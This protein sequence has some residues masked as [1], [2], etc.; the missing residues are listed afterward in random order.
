MEEPAMLCFTI[1]FPLVCSYFAHC[2]HPMCPE[3]YPH[4]KSCSLGLC[5]SFLEEIA[6]QAANCIMDACAEQRK[7][8]EQLLPKHC[9]STISKAQN[10]KAQKQPPKKGEPEWDKPGAESQRKDWILVTK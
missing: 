1:A 10:K 9:A 8:S 4:L 7:L 6:K 5:N 2:I 3:E